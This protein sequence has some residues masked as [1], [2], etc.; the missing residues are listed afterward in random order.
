MVKRY[1]RPDDLKAQ[2]NRLGWQAQVSNT[3][4]AFIYG[5]ARRSPQTS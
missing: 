1:W 2:L 5:V 4:W 3:D